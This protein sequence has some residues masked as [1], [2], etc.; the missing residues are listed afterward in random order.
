MENNINKNTKT[1]INTNKILKEILLFLGCGKGN[2]K[3]GSTPS[4]HED[5]IATETTGPR[6]GSPVHPVTRTTVDPPVPQGF[7]T[8]DPNSEKRR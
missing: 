7:Q 8:E 6:V 4:S 2:P 3:F 1:N 5:S